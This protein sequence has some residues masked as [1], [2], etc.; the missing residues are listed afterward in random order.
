MVQ[1]RER[2]GVRGMEIDARE[3]DKGAICNEL[4]CRIYKPTAK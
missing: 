3:G 4:I 2:A 1:S